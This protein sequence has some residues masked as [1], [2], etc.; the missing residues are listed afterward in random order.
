MGSSILNV[1]QAKL[2]C[3]AAGLVAVE[4]EIKITRI[5]PT[6]TNEM[7]F[8]LTFLVVIPSLASSAPLNTE[9]VVD[10]IESQH[11]LD[12]SINVDE[13]PKKQVEIDSETP[14]GSQFA[15][16]FFF[17]ERKNLETGHRIPLHLFPVETQ[18][19]ILEVEQEEE[20]EATTEAG[21]KY[22]D[23]SSFRQ[24]TVEIPRRESAVDIT[25]RNLFSPSLETD[26]TYQDTLSVFAPPSFF[27]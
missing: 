1:Y 3:G 26:R 7:F 11:D 24:S 14:L 17:P 5:F 23:S 18:N 21:E 22:I 10:I 4:T 13:R 9:D 27:K 15:V 2:S 19:K 16:E 20:E 6:K 8:S 25:L 12:N